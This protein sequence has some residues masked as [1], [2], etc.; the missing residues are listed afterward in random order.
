MVITAVAV[1]RYVPCGT[2]PCVVVT[3]IAMSTTVPGVLHR[4]GDSAP[5]VYSI[6]EYAVS[7]ICSWS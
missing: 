5:L 2:I 1:P 7:L 4:V 6:R 3:G